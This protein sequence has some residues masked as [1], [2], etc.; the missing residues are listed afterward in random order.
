ML[1]PGASATIT[2]S[3][4]PPFPESL[5]LS[6]QVS[7]A[8]TEV[9]ATNN[10]ALLATDVDFGDVPPSHPFHDFVGRIARGG[11]TAGCGGGLFCPDSPVTRAQMAVF[12]LRGNDGASYVPPPATGTVFTD[13]PAGSFAAAWIEELSAR[14][15][16]AGCGGGAYCP[17]AS[18]TRAQMAVFLLRTKLGSGYTSPAASG[19]FADLPASDPFARWAEDL[20]ARGITAG[21]ATAPLRYCPS[22]PVTRGQTA[23]F[24]ATTFGLP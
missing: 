13:V 21:C 10:A 7:G 2:I 17:G 8:E 5:Q 12:L 24:V 16:T 22:S 4:T 6:A 9:D 23:V 1:G 11:V 18:V 19:I 14:A 3:A 20:Y 15:I